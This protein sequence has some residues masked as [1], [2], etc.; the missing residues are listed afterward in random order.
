MEEDVARLKARIISLGEVYV[1]P[2]CE[3]PRTFS[4]STAG[5]GAGG[6]AL[7][8]SFRGTRAKLS[9]TGDE[10]APLHLT[11]DRLF[12]SK[13]REFPCR[14]GVVPILL[15]CPEQ[16]F[17]NVEASCSMDCAFCS[18][19]LTPEGVASRMTED[20][21]VSMILAAAKEPSFRAVA[22]TGGASRDPRAS[23]DKML[24]VLTRVR[25]ALPTV[26]I[27]VEPY[28]ADPSWVDELK[29]AGAD[30]VKINVE[31]ATE[32]LARNVCPSRDR[33]AAFGA[34]E[35]AVGLFGKGKVTSNLIYG[36]GET[37]AELDECAERLAS[38]GV[39]PNLR[40]LKVD[41]SNRGRLRKALGAAP[42]HPTA[43]R[44]LEVARRHKA[45]LER[46][47]LTTLSFKTMCFPCGCCDIVPFRDI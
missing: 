25:K 9:L 10:R 40:A 2:G 11:R 27:G 3:L 33:D 43:K 18:T 39:V 30:E 22:L 36:L 7:A 47:G 17:V 24:R 28:V 37:D 35:R 14:V 19:P 13:G 44:M 15:H 8:F 1:E 6:R 34:L 38:M 32:G 26:P 41:G 29:A 45:M 12:V 23:F 42:R 16:A 20:R 4:R 21:I 46:N 31:A 5:P